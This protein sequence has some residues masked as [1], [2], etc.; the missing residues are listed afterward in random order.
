MDGFFFDVYLKTSA[1]GLV[2]HVWKHAWYDEPEAEV[3]EGKVDENFA[4][5]NTLKRKVMK[6]ARQEAKAHGLRLREPHR[7]FLGLQR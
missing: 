1:P 4:F 7:M 6:L 5:A 2:V 3:I